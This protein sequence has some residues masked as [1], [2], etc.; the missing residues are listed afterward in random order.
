MLLYLVTSKIMWYIMG[1]Y[2]VL[3]VFL[4]IPA[5]VAYAF[6]IARITPSPIHVVLALIF[7]GIVG[8]AGGCLVGLVTASFYRDAKGKSLWKLNM[9]PF[10]TGVVLMWLAC[11]G[12]LSD[13]TSP[14]DSPPSRNF[15]SLLHLRHTWSLFSLR[16]S[17]LSGRIIV[18]W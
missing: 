14:E 18:E 11:S 7:S 17:Y 9:N 16:C 12:I 6:V 5:S 4:V 15:N 10:L 1:V 2:H 8:L 3:G 13:L